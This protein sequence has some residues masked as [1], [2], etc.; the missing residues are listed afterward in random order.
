M[1]KTNDKNLEALALW[2]IGVNLILGDIPS[3]LSDLL[4]PEEINKI[5]GIRNRVG[6]EF[7]ARSGLGEDPDIAK[8]VDEVRNR[9]N[10]G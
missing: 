3:D 7:L 4:T 1:T 10:L 5:T 6:H 9:A 2:E 8:A